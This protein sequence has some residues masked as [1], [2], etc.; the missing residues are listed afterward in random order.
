VTEQQAVMP[1]SR[2][3]LMS[4]DRHDGTLEWQTTLPAPHRA[5]PMQ[6][7]DT[8]VSLAANPFYACI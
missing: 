1:G 3:H 7:G 5:A 2:F 8:I 4:F 6:V